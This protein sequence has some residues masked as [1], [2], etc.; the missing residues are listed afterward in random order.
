MRKMQLLYSEEEAWQVKVEHQH[1]T[2]QDLEVMRKMQVL[3]SEEEAWQ[4]KVEHQ[5]ETHQDLEVMRKMQ[6]LYSEEEAW[7]VKVVAGGYQV[8]QPNLE[9]EALQEH[10][11][12][13]KGR[14]FE[15][16]QMKVHEG[17]IQEKYLG[18]EAWQVTQE[19]AAGVLQVECSSLEEEA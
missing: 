17:Q 8:E 7:Q 5:H 9:E 16:H 1:E 14:Q 6:V 2:Q 18:E 19:K 4:V 13:R 10:W 3:Y 15:E 11:A 12:V